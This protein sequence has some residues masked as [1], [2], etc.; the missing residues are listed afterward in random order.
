MQHQIS[1]FLEE[2]RTKQGRSPNTIVAYRNDL[3]QFAQYLREQSQPNLQKW[4]E[5]TADYLQRYL[6]FLKTADASY[7]ATT[8]AR[9]VAAVKCFCAHLHRR[10]QLTGAFA[11]LIQ[12]PK[13]PKSLPV[14]LSAEEVNLLL[15]APDAHQDGHTPAI[16]RDKALLE[17]LYATGV[18]VTELVALNLVDVDGPGRRIDC[19]LDN[20]R[21]RTL[22]LNEQAG[23][24]LEHYL[25]EGRLAL[26]VDRSQPALFL[27]H[28][29]QRLTR[30]GLWLIIKRYVEQAGITLTVT[31]HTLRN[32][33]AA[34]LLH[35]GAAPREVKERL[36]YATLTS[37]QAH[38]QAA[39]GTASELVIDGVSMRKGQ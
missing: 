14:A 16:L 27:N 24:A 25:S 26:L 18:R 5:L 22:Q 33:L 21:K 36:G 6:S 13:A 11:Q 23:Q 19:G 30:Q 15:A 3:L 20:K 1:E 2:L 37:A 29:G 31:P 8:I 4:S 28:R 34:H 32:S 35:A 17:T 10:G 9:K 12:A 39:N 38:Q 7:S